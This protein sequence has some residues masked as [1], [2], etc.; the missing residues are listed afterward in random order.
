MK[1]KERINNKEIIKEQGFKYWFTNVYWYHYRAHTIV[2]LAIIVF[3]IYSVVSFVTSREEEVDFFFAIVTVMPAHHAQGEMLEEFFAEHGY[4]TKGNVMSLPG[5]GSDMATWQLLMVTLVNEQY[6]LYIVGESMLYYFGEQA[7]GFWAIEELGLQAS[8]LSPMY[9]D[10]SETLMLEGLMLNLEPMYA[11]V[12]API[13]QRNGEFRQPDIERGLKA[14]E[15][16][17]LLLE[18]EG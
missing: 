17:R 7:D 6:A 15:G 2:G 11:L 8:A 13:I 12:R 9:A 14:A 3:A 16:I 10:L 1:M 18:Y 5:D 4:R